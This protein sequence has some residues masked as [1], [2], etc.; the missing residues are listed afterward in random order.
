MNIGIIADDLTSAA[1][2]ALPFFNEG[3][4]CEVVRKYHDKSSADV[5]S[6][7]SNSRHFSQQDA[8]DVVSK[9][10]DQLSHRDILLK[11]VDSTLRGHIKSE[12]KASFLASNKEQIV[13][14]PAFPAAGRTTRNGLQYIHGILVA[15]SKYKND[16]A[17]PCKSSKITDLL[18][19][20]LRNYIILPSDACAEEIKHAMQD[21][22][23][24]ILDTD[25]Q[26]SLNRLVSYI[27]NPNKI[28]WVGS[29]GL[30]Y[31]LA[32]VYKFSNQS[33]PHYSNVKKVLVVIGSANDISKQQ[34]NALNYQEISLDQK[35][36]DLINFPDIAIISAPKQ[37][38]GS[39]KLLLEKISLQ[40]AQVLKAG[41][42]QALIATGGETTNAILEHLR[43][44][45]FSIVDEF[46][47]GF[48]M[49]ITSS[50]SFSSP[51]VI[52]LKAGG[53]GTLESLKNAVEK[54]TQF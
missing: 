35:T 36:S 25:T 31:A 1:D 16:P 32:H 19:T 13:I 54:L 52:G 24:I 41:G 3:A 45:N 9:F 18:A 23:V 27:S 7:D 22:K 37:N 53:F 48:P 42:Y 15:H 11:T 8:C 12:I 33:K 30:S 43:V 17:H 2:A 49:G 46:E 39:P 4:S 10:S 50:L 5:L 29:V 44:D 20:S 38:T 47:P 21:F 51:L 14:A 28:L 40:A 6:V 26:E 34:R